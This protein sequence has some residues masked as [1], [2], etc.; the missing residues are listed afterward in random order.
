MH[1]GP[2]FAGCLCLVFEWPSRE[3]DS[4]CSVCLPVLQSRAL[5]R[6]QARLSPLPLGLGF[7][8]WER[9]ENVR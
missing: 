5:L 7:K 4:L 3:L 6:L 9:L 8:M 1:S 2:S